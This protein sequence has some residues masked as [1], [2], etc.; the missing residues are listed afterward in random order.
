[1]I[2]PTFICVEE[3]SNYCSVQF[4]SVFHWSPS[5]G[6]PR[7]APASFVKATKPG[8]VAQSVRRLTHD[9]EIPGS[10]PGPVTYFRFSFR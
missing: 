8:R 6:E 2:N 1:M 9:P 7:M 10:K 5:V 3:T 4:F